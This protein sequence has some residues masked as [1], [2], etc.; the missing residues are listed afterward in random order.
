MNNI[1]LIK[2]DLKNTVIT[3][4]E[5]EIVDKYYDEVHRIAEK[6]GYEANTCDFDWERIYNKG[7]QSKEN[8]DD[9]YI[10][11]LEY[12]MKELENSMCELRIKICE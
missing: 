3:G 4:T 7:Y 12:K 1:D 8:W 11:S 2:E 10:I 6:Y 5:D 9:E